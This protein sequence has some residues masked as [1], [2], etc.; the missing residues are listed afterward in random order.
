MWAS[1]SCLN[2]VGVIGMV[3]ARQPYACISYGIFQGRAHPS[4]NEY[5]LTTHKRL[6]RC[7]IRSLEIM[8]WA[9]KYETE[10]KQ[11]IAVTCINK[12]SAR[13]SPSEWAWIHEIIVLSHRGIVWW[14]V[15]CRVESSAGLEPLAWYLWNEGMPCSIS[16]W[17]STILATF[18]GVFSTEHQLVASRLTWQ[19]LTWRSREN[20]IYAC[21]IPLCLGLFRPVRSLYHT[22]FFWYR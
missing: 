14:I 13:W 10:C 7:Y 18:V 21:L 19:S 9:N 3:F 17:L 16:G 1:C 11:N 6:Y 15:C 5:I 20:S 8:I 12:I 4:I 22:A 2:F